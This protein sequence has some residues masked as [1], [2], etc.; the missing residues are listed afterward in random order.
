MYKP[1]G[2]IRGRDSVD[3]VKRTGLLNDLT[4]PRLRVGGQWL[5]PAFLLVLESGAQCLAFQL[6]IFLYSNERY[7][8]RPLGVV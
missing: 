2:K 5:I 8:F 1:Q 3:Q 6:Q 4:S 7:A